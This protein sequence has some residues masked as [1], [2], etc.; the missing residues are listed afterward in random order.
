MTPD[1]DGPMGPG[2][3]PSAGRRATRPFAGG[4]PH[5]AAK[6][7]HVQSD[8]PRLAQ[9]RHKK[10]M[11]RLRWLCA[12]V[13]FLAAVLAYFA[14][15]YGASASILGDKFD[16]I[17]ALFSEG[18]GFPFEIRAQ[19]LQ[20]AQP[21]GG[22]FAMLTE[23]ELSMYA[24][25]GALLRTVPHSFARPAMAAGDS[26]LC[27][28]HR[29]GTSLSVESR[30]RT[31]WE[32]TTQEAIELCA[33]SPGGTLAV[34]QR[35][36]VSV[37]TPLFE[38]IFTFYTTEHVTA[39]AFASDN[40]HFA[41]ACPGSDDGALSGR[42]YLF[43]TDTSAEAEADAVLENPAGM[44]L[45]I[46]YL[47]SSR[48]VVV[49]DNYMALYDAQA[50]NELSRFDYGGLSLQSASMASSGNIALLFGDGEHSA[51]TRVV[52][53]DKTLNVTGQ[54]SVGDRTFSVT[55]GREAAYVL[56]AGGVYCYGTDGTLWGM[57]ETASRP[58]AVVAGKK[59][60]LLTAASASELQFTAPGTAPKTGGSSS[61]V[62]SQ[63]ESGA[64]SQS[65]AE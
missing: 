47:S 20:S 36:Q 9:I 33:M 17:T 8:M 51:Q 38:E 35:G 52:M 55:A 19:S 34:A 7:P 37:Y 5:R 46:F 29:G 12:C 26:R 24:A 14:G 39:M 1:T 63:P 16:S 11:R 25:N 50:G 21:L 56:A 22:G 53:F 43:T 4:M 59:T 64:Q 23:N 18:Q 45:K 60:V 3:Q 61:G 42:V 62:Q 15:L 48:V 10:R 28:Y 27:L 40:K 32:F 58:L 2:R 41:V 30:S 31:L 6:R 49:Y 57:Q 54:A 44:P 65:A 13:V